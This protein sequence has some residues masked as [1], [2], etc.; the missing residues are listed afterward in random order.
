MVCDNENSKKKKKNMDTT[1]TTKKIQAITLLHYLSVYPSIQL[2]IHLLSIP[3]RL[4]LL[5]LELKISE[6]NKR[7]K[8]K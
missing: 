1:T 8:Y 7:G 4:S 5:F 2:S 3:A 6:K